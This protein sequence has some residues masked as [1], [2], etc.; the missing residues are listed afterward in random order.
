MEGGTFYWGRGE[1][2]HRYIYLLGENADNTAFVDM[3]LWSNWTDVAPGSAE[4]LL[5]NTDNNARKMYAIVAEDVPFGH[6]VGYIEIWGSPKIRKADIGNSSGIRETVVQMPPD[7]KYY[8]L[9][10]R[11]LLR[12]SAPGLY[13]LPN[14]KKGYCR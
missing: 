9:Q 6:S 12:P 14:K 2:G 4:Y 8:D 7:G 5:Q 1:D 13:I 10:G 3:A 11:R